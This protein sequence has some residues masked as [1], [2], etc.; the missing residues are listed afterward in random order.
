VTRCHLAH[1]SLNVQPSERSLKQAEATT[2]VG[3][4]CDV[5]WISNGNWIAFN[6]VDFYARGLIQFTT[7][8]SSGAA[9][10]ITG[11]VQVSIDSPTAF[12]VVVFAISNTGTGG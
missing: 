6:N 4:G 5:G 1:I 10:G 2:D 9:D 12:P 3:G 11:L 8:F 7:R